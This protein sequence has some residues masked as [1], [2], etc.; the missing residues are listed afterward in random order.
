MKSINKKVLA[1]FLAVLMLMS[2]MAVSVSAEPVTPCDEHTFGN[3]KKEVVEA[4]CTS[5]GAKA[6]VCEVCGAI[7]KSSFEEIPVKAHD[8]VKN[9]AESF[10]AT[11]DKA[12][13]T[14]YN[15]ANCT[16]TKE[17][18]VPV[19]KH[20]LANEV[21]IKA[22][23]CKEAG[24]LEKTCTECG[25]AVQ[26]PIA[27]LTVHQRVLPVERVEPSCLAPGWEAWSHCMT[28]GEYIIEPVEIP[29]LPHQYV[30]ADPDDPEKTYYRKEATCTKDGEFYQQCKVCKTGEIL[31]IPATG[32]KDEDQDG[33]CDVCEANMCSC[34]CHKDN[35]ISRLVRFI[36][37]FFN[38]VFKKD[39][40]DP[41]RFRCCDCMEPNT[42]L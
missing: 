34:V 31:P 24:I 22:A 42:G 30:T 4:T 39:A 6:F 12:G 37:T 9:E 3:E 38:I 29:A 11:C 35:F 21:V 20:S 23:T 27:K 32:H 8:F 13:L 14:K 18:V 16:A 33:L 10:D 36:N 7:D 40:N 41:T 2:A 25:F 19:K 5:T 1:L 28:C 26:F 17:E 15:C